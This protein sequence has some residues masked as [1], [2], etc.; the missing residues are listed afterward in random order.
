MKHSN[1]VIK[2]FMFY[3]HRIHV[4]NIPIIILI[5]EFKK[6]VLKTLGTGI[7]A[8]YYFSKHNVVQ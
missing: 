4:L 3:I 2:Q 8:I 5:T 1:P 6:K 7:I